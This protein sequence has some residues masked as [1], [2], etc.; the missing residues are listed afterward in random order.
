MATPESAASAT[1]RPHTFPTDD[2]RAFARP[3][4]RTG[5]ASRPVRGCPRPVRP[6]PRTL[7][8]SLGCP[9]DAGSRRRPGSTG[10]EPRDLLVPP[11]RDPGLSPSGPTG[12]SPLSG[13]SVPSVA[14][15]RHVRSVRWT[16]RS[17]LDSSDLPPQGRSRGTAWRL[18]YSSDTAGWRLRR[19]RGVLPWPGGHRGSAF[20]PAFQDRG[21]GHLKQQHVS[22]LPSPGFPEPN[23]SRGPRSPPRGVH[24]LTGNRPGPVRPRCAAGW[25]ETRKL[26]VSGGVTAMKRRTT[27]SRRPVLQPIAGKVERWP[28]HPSG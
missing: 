10:T 23:A 8:R 13:T 18:R 20:R 21:Y 4:R 26:S 17:T 12:R 11:C 2:L 22:T 1:H 14:V 24:P 19:S 7:S 27:R 9:V 5:P 6:A 3:R 28:L 25:N 16:L 15:T